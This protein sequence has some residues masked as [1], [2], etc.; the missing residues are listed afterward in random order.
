MGLRDSLGIY[1]SIF[2]TIPTLAWPCHWSSLRMAILKEC[3]LRALNPSTPSLA[4]FTFAF[5]L[6]SAFSISI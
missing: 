3:T 6:T 4:H 5:L 2:C 1:F